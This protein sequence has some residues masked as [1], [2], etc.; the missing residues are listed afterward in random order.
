VSEETIEIIMRAIEGGAVDEHFAVYVRARRHDQ[1]IASLEAIDA[2]L[3]EIVGA[4]ITIRTGIRTGW[5]PEL[6]P[7]ISSTVVRFQIAAGLI[8][9]PSTRGL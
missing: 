1:Y 6:A 9:L 8:R 7:F 4:P 5:V 3:S 2:K